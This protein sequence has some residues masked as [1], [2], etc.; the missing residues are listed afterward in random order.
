MDIDDFSDTVQDKVKQWLTAM[1]GLP[2][3]IENEP[4]IAFPHSGGFWEVSPANAITPLG[5][6][7][8]KYEDDP[9]VAENVIPVV[10]G[11]RE[12]TVTLRA[13]VRSQTAKKTARQLVEKIRLSLKKPTVLEHF[14]SNGMAIVRLG[15]TANYDST[16]DN[17]VESIAA[18]EFRL[19]CALTDSDTS[20]GTIH[21][22]EVTSHLKGVDGVELPSPPNLNEELFTLPEE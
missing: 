14:Q 7:E 4:V 19:S 13:I 3:R 20:V 8:L 21:T 16:Y 15:P 9:D 2:A 11:R 22:I 17:R 10:A 18:A 5:E 6:D 1:T 12:F